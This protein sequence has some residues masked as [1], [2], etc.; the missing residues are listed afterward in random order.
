MAQSSYTVAGRDA[1]I[2]H[3]RLLVTLEEL[4]VFGATAGGGVSREG[5]TPADDSAR[6]HLSTLARRSGLYPSIDEAGN[7]IVR[8]TP[9]SGDQ[10]VLV[11]GSHIDSVTAGGRLDGVYGVVAGLEVLRAVAEERLTTGFEPV[12]IAFSN[13]E[14]ARF[15]YPF[16]G[17]RA[18]VGDLAEPRAVVD[19]TGRSIREALHRAGGDLDRVEQAAWLAGSIAAYLELHVEQGPVLE[20]AG[21]PIGVVRAITG[22]VILQAEIVGRQGHAGTTPMTSRADAL[23]AASELV[24]AV[25]RL[26]ADGGKCTA[27]TT[28]SLC[29]EPGLSNVIPGRAGLTI[30]LRDTDPDR[31]LSAERCLRAEAERIAA[32]SRTAVRIGR[33]SVSDPVSTSP[34]LVREITAAAEELGFGSMVMSSGAGHDAQIVA[35][36]APVGL[37]FVPSTDGV[38][39]SPDEHTDAE[40]LAAGAEVLAATVAR[41]TPDRD[42][43]TARLPHE[44]SRLSHL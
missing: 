1:R 19:R 16:W 26:A 20:R 8:L 36:V 29:V 27:A 43:R 30:E 11:I 44:L 35:Q 25:R 10:P 38:S 7:L 4:A 41:L 22:R 6:S 37:I 40:L 34:W 3:E 13:E 28:G 23:V 15:P 42:G 39:H 14:G 12:L 17:S 9:A 24:L 5:F 33:S 31:L 21:L 18:V 32:D 2:D